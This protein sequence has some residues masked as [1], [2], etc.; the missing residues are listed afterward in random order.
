MNIRKTMT[1][2]DISASGMRAQRRRMDAVASNIANLETTYTEACEPYRRKIVVMQSGPASRSFDQ[3]LMREDRRIKITNP[4]HIRTVR[5]HNPE[6]TLGVPVES[7]VEVVQ[8]NAFRVVYDPD[9]PDADKDGYVRLPNI[10]V[11]TEM[12]DMI[13]A[14]RSYEANATVIDATKTMTKKALEI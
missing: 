11:I 2:L 14:S 7:K 5:S 8:N 1:A 12:V 6:K 3:L 4:K 9:H 13:T 10:N